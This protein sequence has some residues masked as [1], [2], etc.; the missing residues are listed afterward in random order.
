MT[1]EVDPQDRTARARI[2]DAAIHRF[3]EHGFG[4]THLK[5]IAAD[6]GVT[7]P[8]I[9]H[10]FGSKSGLRAAC[11]EHIAALIKSLKQRGVAEGTRGD[12]MQLLRD[13]YAGTPIT[14]YLARTLADGSDNVDDLIDLIVEDAVEYTRD[15]ITQGLIRPLDNLREQ[16]TV[17]VIWNLGT[18]V[19]NRQVERLLDVDLVGGDPRSIARWS[20]LATGILTHGVI[21]PDYTATLQQSLA[22]AA[23]DP[24]EESP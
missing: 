10:H 8:L 2:R 21:D 1:G 3:A 9:T 13:S 4:R 12:I 5:D 17:L 6:A 11:D 15:G 22:R 18:L 14:G 16:V 19:L 7:T 20:S 24:T 23:T